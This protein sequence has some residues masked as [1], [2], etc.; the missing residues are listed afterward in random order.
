[1]RGVADRARAVERPGG[2]SVLLVALL[3]AVSASGCGQLDDSID[4]LTLRLEEWDRHRHDTAGKSGQGTALP[5]QA[6]VREWEPEPV[7][8]SARVRGA[9][10]G[11]LAV[12]RADTPAAGETGLQRSPPGQEAQPPRQA[13]SYESP[14]VKKGLQPGVGSA[15]ARTRVAAP[16][17][18]AR[19]WA[20][21]SKPVKAIRQAVSVSAPRLQGV[22]RGRWIQSI[23]PLDV[24][25]PLMGGTSPPHLLARLGTPGRRSP[26]AVSR[27]TN[28]EE[29]PR[30][31]VAGNAA[32]G[33][34]LARGR[35]GGL[36]PEHLHASARRGRVARVPPGRERTLAEVRPEWDAGPPQ[37]GRVRGGLERR[38]PERHQ[39]HR[40]CPPRGD[41]AEHR[42]RRATAGLWD[43]ARPW[44]GAPGLRPRSS[45]A[46]AG[47]RVSE[48]T[49]NLFSAATS[50][51][52]GA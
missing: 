14:R 7:R 33:P 3:L 19:W 15:M 50:V 22:V 52:Q 9:L 41:R 37:P 44:P 2:T 34:V 23:E 31:A 30:L 43:A 36:R 25:R 5:H 6:S 38:A 46:R 29:P 51:R 8:R 20:A 42:A 11:G 21:G 27:H 40:V 12:S 48:A 26:E 32:G 13:R 1:M 39:E 24:E 35:A 10:I 49:R 28:Q 47:R 4:S 16:E 45:T 17:G 18:V